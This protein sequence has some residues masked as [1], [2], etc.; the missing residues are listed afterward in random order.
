MFKES[1]LGAI[2]VKFP[3]TFETWDGFQ[4]SIVA[5]DRVG[6]EPIII[7]GLYNKPT[8]ETPAN[9][10]RA[11]RLDVDNDKIDSGGEKLI[12]DE[13]H[14][15]YPEVFTKRDAEFKKEAEEAQE[16]DKQPELT[17]VEEIE[18]NTDSGMY[19]RQD[20]DD[21]RNGNENNE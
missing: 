21:W 1:L 16:S 2:Q 10:H 8:E 19:L 17:D 11:F 6:L 20:M 12:D 7:V 15:V 4:T 3:K 13:M 18:S 5:N 9:L 14:R